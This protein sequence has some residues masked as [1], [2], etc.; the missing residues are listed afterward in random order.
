MIKNPLLNKR[1]I[2][3]ERALIS[4]YDKTRVV[5]FPKV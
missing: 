4:V 5:E 3:I 2:T 1:N